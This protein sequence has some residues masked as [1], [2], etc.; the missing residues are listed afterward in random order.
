MRWSLLLLLAAC[1]RVGFDARGDARGGD[2]PPATHDEDGDGVPD[3]L[4]TCPHLVAPQLDS[5][6]D[7]VGDACDPEPA[8]ARQHVLLFA[9]LQPGD[10]PFMFNEPL[11][12]AQLEDAIE[13]DGNGGVD[14]LARTAAYPSVRV[15]IGVT[16]RE[17]LGGDGVQH[18]IALHAYDPNVP[19]HDF[20][21]INEVLPTFS[22]AQISYYDGALYHEQ[23]AQGLPMHV[24]TGDFTLELTAAA[25]GQLV[26]AA[27]WPG[28]T[29]ELT[30]P[31]ATI[32]YGGGTTVDID[33]NNVVADIRYVWA[34]TW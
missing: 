21:E 28:E 31:D 11:E 24:H 3:A 23:T 7:G 20:V 19:A 29:Y 26:L 2:A 34:I 13:F 15:Q 16:I 1:G 12:V 9:T 25:G 5:D 22:N 33:I 10:Q 18:Q 6:G 14:M 4:D 32:T 8:N 27:G 17:V 30:E